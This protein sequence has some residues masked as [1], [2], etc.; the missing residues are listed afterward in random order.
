[1]SVFMSNLE[2]SDQRLWRTD[3]NLAPPS[4]FLLHHQERRFVAFVLFTVE[5]KLGDL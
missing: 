4:G 2:P 3:I 5:P 1:M